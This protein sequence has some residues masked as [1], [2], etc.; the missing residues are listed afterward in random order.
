VSTVIDVGKFEERAYDDTISE[1]LIRTYLIGRV[2]RTDNKKSSTTESMLTPET[3][4]KENKDLQLRRVWPS[5]EEDLP[6]QLDKLLHGHRR[7]E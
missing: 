4:T 5:L 3:C 2:K 7:P 6:N 1:S